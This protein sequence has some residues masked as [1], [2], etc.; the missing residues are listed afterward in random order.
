MSQLK[1]NK[2]CTLLEQYLSYLVIVKGRSPLTAE[3]YRIDCLMLLAFVKQS[4]G[5]S[6]DILEKR[7][8]SDVDIDFIK[9]ITVA[10]MYAFITYCGETRGVTTATRARKIVSIRQFWKYLKNKA[11]LLENNI[12]EELE[13]P[14]LPKR[15]PK[16]LSLDESIRGSVSKQFL[17]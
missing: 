4:R 3:E 14:K 7:D 9:S 17:D 6:S 13:T 1:E 12:A 5:V 8:F 16:Y 15:M 2:T 11:H 10:D